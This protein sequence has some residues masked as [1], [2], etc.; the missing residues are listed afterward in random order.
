MSLSESSQNP[1]HASVV[2]AQDEAARTPPNQA[3]KNPQVLLLSMVFM[4]SFGF[5]VWQVLLNNFVIERANFTGV[6]IGIL[7]SLREVPGFL[8]FT[9]VFLLLI[10]KEQYF[11]LLSIAV[12]GLGIALTGFLPFE[13]G[14]YFTTVVMSIGF[15]YFETM[16]KSLTLQWIDKKE[17][18]HFMGRALAIKSVASL[19]AYALI[20]LGMTFLHIDY[21]WMYLF[22]GASVIALSAVLYFRFPLFPAL[23]VQ[24]KHLFLRKR[25]WLYYSLV[26]LSGARRQIFVVFAGFMMVE[27]FGYSVR[28]ISLLFIANYVFNFFFAAK[29]GRFIG[30]VGERK[31]LVFEYLG[32]ICVFAGYAF[33]THP[34]VAAGLYIVDHLFFALAIAVS[35]YFQKIAEPEDIAGTASVS[36]TINHIAAVVIPALLGLVWVASPTA[37]FMVGVGFACL[38]LICSLNIPSQPD[39]DNAVVWGKKH[40]HA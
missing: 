35:T 8:A 38:S 9:A 15:H 10:F 30:V 3:W 31:A 23:V 39:T 36:F 26:F 27:K 4:M 24:R 40:T 5:G 29:I 22:V 16:N 11:A 7:Q 13:Y 6:E 32:L 1:A 19:S 25:Y 20:L 28:D 21:V 18:P 2:A 12:M 34:Y 37:V 33:V 17:T 14:L